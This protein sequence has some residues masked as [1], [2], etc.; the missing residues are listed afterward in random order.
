M[1]AATGRRASRSLEALAELV[2]FERYVIPEIKRMAVT[3][4]RAE[5]YS[6]PQ[7]GQALGITSQ[8]VGQVYGLKA[9]FQTERASGGERT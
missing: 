3:G 6:D 2:N 4:L 7:I 5:G 9:D 1:L 8:R